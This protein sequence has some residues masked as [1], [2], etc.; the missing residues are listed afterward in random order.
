[1]APARHETV[2]CPFQFAIDRLITTARAKDQTTRVLMSIEEI[3]TQRRIIPSRAEESILQLDSLV[4]EDGRM[5]LRQGE[6]R[7]GF[8]GFG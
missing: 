5:G 3:S 4:L 8:A 7:P 2:L 1:M 6:R